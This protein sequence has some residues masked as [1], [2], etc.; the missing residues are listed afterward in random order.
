MKRL[1]G[2]VAVSLMAFSG[3]AGAQS[4][5]IGPAAGFTSGDEVEYVGFVPFEVGSSTGVSIQGKYMY[6]T[7]WKSLS[8]YDISDPAS[9]VLLSQVPFGFAFENE[10]VSVTPDGRYLYFSEQ[11]PDNVLHVWDVEDKTSPAEVVTLPGA[12]GH[13][14]SC[15]LKCK[16]LYS[17]EGTV[18]DVR[19]PLE[20]KI[21]EG[22]DWRAEALGQP[23]DM[24]D[25]FEVR[26]GFIIDSPISG[27]FHYIDVRNPLKPKL[28][29]SGVK[30]AQETGWLFH[31]GDWPNNATDDFILMQGEDNFNPRCGDQNGPFQTYDARNWQKSKT[32]QVIDSYRVTNGVY[33]DGSPAANGLGCSAH[34]FQN[35]P[36][37]RNGGLVGVGY[38]EHG[39]RFLQVDSNGKIKEAGWFIPNGGSTSGFWWASEKKN[40]RIGYAVDY[41]RGIDILR[42]NGDF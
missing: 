33:A 23:A 35:H 15:V 9:P 31:S 25:V 10:Q 8:I 27:P 30:E 22:L 28:V 29:A 1:L 17:S 7:S 21:I 37:F 38:Y 20:P 39:T 12:G 26:N 34:W 3:V 40:E 4:V 18:V 41:T 32:F 19:N 42:W 24:H 16:W 11:L 6:L 13:T 36:T 2:L 14:Q 5:P